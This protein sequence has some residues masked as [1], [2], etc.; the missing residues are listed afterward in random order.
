[1]LKNGGKTFDKIISNLE[2]IAGRENLHRLPVV[3]F[4]LRRM[5]RYETTGHESMYSGQVDA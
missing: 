3:P 5:P 1:M 4:L 2:K